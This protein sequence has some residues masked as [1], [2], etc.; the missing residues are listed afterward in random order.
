MK[1]LI[2][3]LL[4]LLVLPM[5]AQLN[6]THKVQVDE[7]LQQIADNFDVAVDEIIKLNE[8]LYDYDPDTP[9]RGEGVEMELEEV[10][11]PL[12][13]IYNQFYADINVG[14][15]VLDLGSNNWPGHYGQA[16]ALLQLPFLF[17]LYT[18]DE[19]EVWPIVSGKYCFEDLTEAGDK[20]MKQKGTS[21]EAGIGAKLQ[22]TN[23][24]ISAL[25]KYK[26]VGNDVTI[27]S[28]F[29]NGFYFHSLGGELEARVYT[30]RNQRDIFITDV[31][32]KLEGMFV[33]AQSEPIVYWRYQP[34][35]HNLLAHYLSL[36]SSLSLIDIPI[37]NWLISLSP[38]VAL[39]WA[40]FNN[41]SAN[42]YYSAGSDLT[43]YCSGLQVMKFFG[44][45]QFGTIERPLIGLEVNFGFLIAQAASY[46]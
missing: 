32:M 22:A 38:N 44:K 16:T 39:T 33:V 4:F 5:A 8:A 43:V 26:Q 46:F 15:A 27:T 40:N 7:T 9:L 31:D 45:Y 20:T 36:Q 14:G 1:Q 41:G 12:S 10:L 24:F 25:A 42:N 2:V 11:I 29:T 37:S 21:W 6:Y 28:G 3:F 13:N 34:L 18:S 19:F 23:Y 17:K 35:S 30:S